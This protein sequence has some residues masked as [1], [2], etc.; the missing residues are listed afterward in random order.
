MHISDIISAEYVSLDPDARVSKLAG[1]FE[2]PEVR[3]VIVHGE[4]FEGVVTR[5]ELATSH[6]HPDG[7]VGSLIRHVPRLAP[8]EDVREV[9]RL[10]I[11][12]DSR[13][14]PVFEGR[15]LRGVVT[16]DDV[17]GAVE[18]YLEAATVADAASKD[19]VTVEP[20]SPV[21]EVLHKFRDNHVTHLPAVADDQA[22]G[23]LSLHDVVAVTVRP[24]HRSQGGDPGGR[25]A[26]G[27]TGTGSTGTTHGGYGAREGELNR[28]L[29]LPV[30]DVMVSPVRTTHSDAT[31]ETAVTAMFD[32]GVSS[33]VVTAD[34]RP[35]G[36]VTKTDVL[37]ALTW[38]AEGNRA[39]EVNGTDLLG[40]TDY[41]E[42]VAMIDRFDDRNSDMAVLGAKIHLH[43]HD[44]RR[45]GT[46]LLLARVRL[47]TDR[48]L[49]VASGEGFGAGQAIATAR[50]VLERRLRDAKTHG[51]S[52]KHPDA[53]FWEQR[54]G[55]ML[56]A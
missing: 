24:E 55:W 44:E 16:V 2:D 6:R 23:I 10:M 49:F 17:L 40:D 39:V 25:D 47:H 51:K 43:E 15:E 11:D 30:R 5:T 36:I 18:P 53:D 38:E 27:G 26:F 7:K 8:D 54:F 20:G 41:D 1:A 46:S 19:L 32:A 29:D 52:K 48:G 3:G 35:T 34:G 28:V 4:E 45:R 22:V 13:V 37:K 42:V 12:S 33:L 14:L 31:L 56:K 9:A 21:D 50:D